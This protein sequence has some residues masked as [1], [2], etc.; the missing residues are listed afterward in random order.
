MNFVGWRPTELALADGGRR[1]VRHVW[2]VG[3]NYAEHVREMGADPSSEPPIFF[4]KP[5]AALVQRDAID[6]PAATEELHHEVELVA[7][8]G[9]A[10]LG[11]GGR[12]MEV[13]KAPACVDAWAVG[14]D[15]T[16]RDVQAR[17]RREGKPWAPAKGFDQSGPVGLLATAADW[18]PQPEHVIELAVDGKPRQRATLGEMIWPVA[19]LIARLSG[20][21]TLYPGDAIFTGTPAGVG[22][23]VPGDRVTSS[24]EGL[25]PLEFVISQ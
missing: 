11:R 4:S 5:A 22:P 17:A 12:N 16:R 1:A 2:C 6:Y 25:P 14:C 19:E 10:G 15:L 21:V 24:I 8:L 23:L 20:E 3:R 7:F 13:A 9:G 18:Q